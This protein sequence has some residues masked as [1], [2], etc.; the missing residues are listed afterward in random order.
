MSGTVVDHHAQDLADTKEGPVRQNGG[1]L[2]AVHV[3]GNR[4]HRRE[5]LEIEQHAPASD[6]TRVHD[7]VHPFEDREDPWVQLAVGVSHHP[8]VGGRVQSHLRYRAPS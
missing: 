7:E 2:A 4:H 3:A 5:G 8:D 6:V 1:Q